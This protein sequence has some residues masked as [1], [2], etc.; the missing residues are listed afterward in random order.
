M[1]KQIQLAAK[2]YGMRNTVKGLHKDDYFD[3]I[4]P[5]MD[6]VK[7]CMQKHNVSNEM[8]AAMRVC[9]EAADLPNAGFFVIN[10]MAAAAEILEPTK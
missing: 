5:Y 10:I 3:H 1:E 8:E 9:N 6:I 7:G 2:I 4:K